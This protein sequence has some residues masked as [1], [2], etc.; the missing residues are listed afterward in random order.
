MEKRHSSPA[1]RA[2]SPRPS[3]YRQRSNSLPMVEALGCSTPEAQ[4]LLAE[5]RAAIR[6][7]NNTRRGRR[8]Q[9]ENSQAMTLRPQDHLKYLEVS[10]KEVVEG[11]KSSASD[12]T[13]TQ[14]ARI[15]SDKSVSTVIPSPTSAT[16]R[17]DPPKSPGSPTSPLDNYSANLADFIKSQLKSI[18]SFQT[19]NYPHSCPDLNV[20]PRI[21]PQSPKKNSRKPIDTPDTI[22]I[23]S[24]RPPLRSAFSAWSS[25]DDEIEDEIFPELPTDRP[26]TEPKTR[27]YTPSILRYYESNYASSFLF[28]TTPL[29]GEKQHP[30]AQGFMF[31]NRE[32]PAKSSE[33]DLLR[34]ED[35]INADTDGDFPPSPPSSR[36]PLGSS[37]V[38]SLSSTSTASYFECKRPTSIAPHIR[39]RLIAAVSPYQDK[40]QIVSVMSPFEGKGM[41]GVHNLYVESQSRVHVDGISFDLVHDFSFPQMQRVPT[42][43]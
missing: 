23:P 13:P 30:N 14:H 21:P 12:I 1:P 40:S 35:Y 8:Y 5:G 32:Q 6:S 42:P 25:T 16:L 24:V 18:P 37:S 22:E 39:D 34:S 10:T 28:S 19:S 29:E 33:A 43:C 15:P 27:I 36:P 26:R 31:P 20:T 7:R 17:S 3:T 38:P 9:T 41:S 2:V 4:L 11:D